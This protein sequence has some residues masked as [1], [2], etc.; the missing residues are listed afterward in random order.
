MIN[1]VMAD[2]PETRRF[3]GGWGVKAVAQDCF[4]N[5][6]SYRRCVDD[7]NTYRGRKTNERRQ[8]ASPARQRGPSRTQSD[9]RSSSSSRSPS[10]G[11]STGK[12]GRPVASDDDDDD[13][14]GDDDLMDFDDGQNPG[15][16]TDGE[17]DSDEEP[18][19]KK[20][21]TQ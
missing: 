15:G 14:H 21:R 5:S 3:D 20:Q 18:S 11:P 9:S 16:A 17:D 7:P 6:K 10:P 13:Q 12:R 1:V 2:F 4:S 19:A 8:R